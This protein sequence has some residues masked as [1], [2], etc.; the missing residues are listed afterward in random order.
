M[1]YM[2]KNTS[3]INL[4]KKTNVLPT[5]LFSNLK[6]KKNKQYTNKRK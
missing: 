4:I 5:S 3:K 2:K 6:K 1:N